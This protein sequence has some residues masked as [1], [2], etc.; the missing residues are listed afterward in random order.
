LLSLSLIALLMG[1]ANLPIWSEDEDSEVEKG[2]ARHEQVLEYTPEY[3]NEKL[4]AF[5]S[6]VGNK[7]AAASD[8]PTLT[9]R[10]TVLDS[11]L[12]N[13]F[14]TLG[15]NVYITR[16]LLIYLR[17]EH[18]LAAVL[19][20]EIAHICRRDAV[21]AKRRSEVAALVAL[22][23]LAAAP[24]I[25]LFPQ[26]IGAPMGMGL[27]AVS[28]SDETAADLLGATYLT[29]AGYPA[30]AMQDA[31]DILRSIE[32]YKKSVNNVRESWW[33]RAYADHP[34]T[35][36]RQ[37]R[38]SALTGPVH[39]DAK[40]TPDI[41]FLAL[42]EGM[43]VGNSAGEGMLHKGKRYFPDLA[44][45]LE[46]R[47]GWRAQA[48]RGRNG[49][50]PTILLM[51]EKA[52]F[53][54]IQKRPIVDLAKNVCDS[55][56][57]TFQKINLEERVPLRSSDAATCT[58]L[59]SLSYGLFSKTMLW[60]RVGIIRLDEEHYLTFAGHIPSEKKNEDEFNEMDRTFVALAKSIEAIAAQKAPD[61][62]R[63]SIYRTRPGDSFEK[64][65]ASTMPADGARFLRAIN[66]RSTEENVVSGDTIKIVK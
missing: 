7:L 23:V 33:H 49:S 10:F 39:S 51:N 45:S 35:T 41:R 31:M 40:R 60:R 55:M 57:H 48:T 37:E 46:I 14:A 66:I 42:L 63:L 44:I 64:L 5:V 19:A 21:H 30:D 17:N 15:G 54:H 65:A 1:C 36:Q 43:E 61:R 50:P 62:P 11:P 56:E 25:M 18:D 53:I 9:W 27:A 59:G 38:L 32:A 29:R 8:R 52:G 47:D 20:H 6:A 3:K 58:A 4:T 24:A 13:A 12:E 34:Q 28:R 16:G 26:A 22:G 2:E